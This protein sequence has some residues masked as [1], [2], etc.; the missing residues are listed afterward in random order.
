MNNAGTC[1]EC[2]AQ[3]PEGHAVKG[4]C[5][6]CLLSLGLKVDDEAD[7][8]TIGAYE[9]ER[10]LGRGGMGV[11]Y[12][13]RQVS[14]NRPVALKVLHPTLSNDPAFVKRRGSVSHCACPIPSAAGSLPSMEGMPNTLCCS[15]PWMTWTSGERHESV[16]RRWSGM[17][18]EKMREFR[19]AIA[20]AV[21]H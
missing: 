12:K 11:V 14:L 17:H 15:S 18:D 4:L 20:S 16:G 10:L 5:P 3:L 7:L 6:R 2:G 9:I 13:A 8:Q 1:S 19:A 21:R